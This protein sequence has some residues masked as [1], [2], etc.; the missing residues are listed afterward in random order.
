MLVATRVSVLLQIQPA[1]LFP[2]PLIAA[3]T[4]SCKD[5]AQF[6]CGRFQPIKMP[7]QTQN[8]VD[9]MIR[10]KAVRRREWDRDYGLF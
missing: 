4:L 9:H 6:G 1:P 3:T 10:S 5:L 8:R 2:A 7:T